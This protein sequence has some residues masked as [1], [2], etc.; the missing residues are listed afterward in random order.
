MSPGDSRD[1]QSS[2]I[3]E[4]ISR[5]LKGEPQQHRRVFS[6][7]P[8]RFRRRHGQKQQ[9]SADDCKVVTTSTTSHLTTKPRSPT[10]K[11]DTQSDHT[12]SHETKGLNETTD[13]TTARVSV[14]SSCK[15]PKQSMHTTCNLAQDR[16]SVF[17]DQTRKLTYILDDTGD[18]GFSPEI[19]RCNVKPTKTGTKP[20]SPADQDSNEANLAFCEQVHPKADAVQNAERDDVSSSMIC[21]S[22][23]LPTFLFIHLDFMSNMTSDYQIEDKNDR[24]RRPSTFNHLMEHQIDRKSSS[25]PKS[26]RGCFYCY[27]T[28]KKYSYIFDCHFIISLLISFCL[29]F[30]FTPASFSFLLLLITSINFQNFN[31]KNQCKLN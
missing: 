12:R 19:E 9:Y 21:S 23:Q 11:V 26:K 15:I 6:L 17:N 29:K 22:N 5:K 3:T 1:K 18:V 31:Y 16:E 28:V 27:Y 10:E 25:S 13:C 4:K 7:S 24:S 8:A 30:I 20:P 2:D 14:T